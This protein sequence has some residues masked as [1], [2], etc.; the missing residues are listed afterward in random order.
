MIL[1]YDQT[2][3][4][5]GGG[6][7]K[8][9]NVGNASWCQRFKRRAVGSRACHRVGSRGKRPSEALWFSLFAEVI[10]ASNH[11]YLCFLRQISFW[12]SPGSWGIDHLATPLS[13]RGQFN[14]SCCLLCRLLS[15]TSKNVHTELNYMPTWQLCYFAAGVHECM[16]NIRLLHY[17]TRN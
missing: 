15:Q 7:R 12:G 5:L 1:S 17:S 13:V 8:Q 11:H 2:R 4:L 16:A 9:Q 14:T 3:H 10:S 6:H